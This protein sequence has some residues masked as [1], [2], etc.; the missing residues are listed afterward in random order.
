MQKKA[1]QNNKKPSNAVQNVSAEKATKT[2]QKK[3]AQRNRAKYECSKQLAEMIQQANLVKNVPQFLADEALEKI[4]RGTPFIVSVYDFLLSLPKEVQNFIFVSRERE[5]YEKQDGYEYWLNNDG[6]AQDKLSDLN[7]DNE[8]SDEVFDRLINSDADEIADFLVD[9]GYYGD[10]Y[11]YINYRKNERESSFS[12]SIFD[13]DDD[14]DDDDEIDEHDSWNRASAYRSALERLHNIR[15]FLLSIINLTKNLEIIST[16]SE[17]DSYHIRKN[18]E[19][20]SQSAIKELTAKKLK[21]KIL[22]ASI[23]INKKGEIN[24]SISEWA[25]ALQGVDITRI[26]ICEVC[27]DIFWANRKDA[28]A[29]SKKHAKVRQMRLLR[30][31]WKESEELYL[32]ARKKKSNK[33]KEN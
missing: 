14:D 28:F 30:A 31:N 25:S 8:I 12:Y 9:R 1:R 18:Q 3:I 7:I 24:F 26:R 29:C 17:E 16:P 27:E 5:D 19:N 6:E 20:F 22:A 11:S 4:K 33:S 10:K 2:P 21:D 13:D 23:T 15:D 32:E